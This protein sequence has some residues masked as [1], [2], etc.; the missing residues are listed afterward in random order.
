[1]IADSL[2]AVVAYDSLTMYRVD[3]EASVRRA[4]VARDRFADVIMD[5]VGPLGVGITGWVIDR[6]EAVLLERR[7]PRSTLDPD[8]G[9]AVRARVDDRRPAGRGW[10]R[11]SGRSTS[12]GWA[13]RSRTSRPNEFELTKL[14][15]GQAS[16]ALQ[17][18]EVHRAVE[19]RAELDSLTGLRNHG[20]FQRE[21]GEAV[22]TDDGTRAGAPDDGSRRVQGVQRHARPSGRRRAAAGDRDRDPGRAPRPRPGV[23]LR[24]RR[25]R[26]HPAGARAR[27]G[28][29]RRASGSGSAVAGQRWPRW[30]AGPA[31]RSGSASGSPRSRTTGDR[32]T[33]SSGRPT[34]TSTWR[35]RRTPACRRAARFGRRRR[36]P[37]GAQRDG[38]RAHGPARP[39]RAA[40][41]DRP[42]GRRPRRDVARV[43]LPRRPGR[44]TTWSWRS[45]PDCTPTSSDTAWPAAWACPGRS[46]TRAS[47][48][49]PPTTTRCRPV[50][51]PGRPASSGA[52]VG[53]PLDLGRRGPRRPR[54]GL[55]RPRRDVRG[56]PGR[57]PPAGSPSS[58]RSPWTTPTCSRAPGT[59]SSSGRRAEEALRISEERYRR[60]SDAT[61][62]ALAIHRDG[63]VLEVNAAFCRL[64]GYEPED[65]VGRRILDFAAPETADAVER[66]ELEREPSG[67]DR[68]PRP[69]PATGRSSRSR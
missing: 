22:A 38:G 8:P 62:E 20:A 51:R 4:V 15:A 19:V 42:P 65:C 60:L 45:G 46:G 1:M 52:V 23:S 24:R 36:L 33:R 50:T 47:R 63:V 10:S 67:A 69:A 40:R 17:N 7:P 30:P 3:R 9:H 13:S 54:P 16:I 32:R 26:G 55:G 21:L 49:S 29:G 43:R 58:P 41:D 57:G 6:N 25:V 18:A 61:S 2:K 34:R 68:G 35:S 64:V 59:R 44:R 11:S 27:P 12:A 66:G 28:R 14:F 37:R 39:D 5:Y 31:G 56:T 48:S 53:I